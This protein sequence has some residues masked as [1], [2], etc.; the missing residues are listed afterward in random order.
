[1]KP[2]LTLQDA[3]EAAAR[4]KIDPKDVLLDAPHAL[5]R[6]VHWDDGSRYTVWTL[7]EKRA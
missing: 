1:M 4:M 7:K 3:I 5:R 6:E 2:L